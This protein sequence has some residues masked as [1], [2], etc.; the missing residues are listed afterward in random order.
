MDGGRG[1]RAEWEEGRKEAEQRDQ[2]PGGIYPRH[3]P[4][5]SMIHGGFPRRLVQGFLQTTQA[6]ITLREVLIW[7]VFCL[8]IS[9]N[10]S[11]VLLLLLFGHAAQLMRS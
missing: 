3:L 1:L 9:C 2:R 4:G 7:A 5:P 10:I 6:G 11:A 8:H